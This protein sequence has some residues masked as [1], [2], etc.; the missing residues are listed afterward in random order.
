MSSNWTRE[1]GGHHSP[2][3]CNRSLYS[4]PGR[5]RDGGGMVWKCPVSLREFVI[6]LNEIEIR[7]LMSDLVHALYLANK[8]CRLFVRKAQVNMFTRT[9]NLSLARN[10]V[11]SW[12]WTFCEFV[13]LIFQ[14]TAVMKC[15]KASSLTFRQTRS[16]RADITIKIVKLGKCMQCD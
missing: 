3:F 11:Y 9:L 8:S 4:F 13:C 1:I 10:S 12:I 16:L 2:P 6:L 7:F 14:E 15:R 5:S